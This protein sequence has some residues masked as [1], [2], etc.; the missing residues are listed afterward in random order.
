MAQE[1]PFA[2]IGIDE[3]NMGTQKQKRLF[4]AHQPALLVRSFLL[5]LETENVSNQVI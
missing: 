3:S 4:C 5:L 1:R 2:F